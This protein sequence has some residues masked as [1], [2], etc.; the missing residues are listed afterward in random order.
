MIPRPR[1]Q[2]IIAGT[3][4]LLAH[5]TPWDVAAQSAS[6]PAPE[7]VLGFPVLFGRAP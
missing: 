3:V 1:G 4:L 5:G 7:S 2:A 6:I